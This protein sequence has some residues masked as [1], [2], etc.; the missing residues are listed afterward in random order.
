MKPYP[1]YFVKVYC[2]HARSMQDACVSSERNGKAHVTC[3]FCGNSR[4]VPKS[5]VPRPSQMANQTLNDGSRPTQTKGFCDKLCLQ[6]DTCHMKHYLD[7]NN[8]CHRKLVLVKKEEKEKTVE[9]E[10]IRT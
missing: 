9:Q 2:P 6:F 7:Q 5:T 3:N 10:T 8:F 1:F 4:W